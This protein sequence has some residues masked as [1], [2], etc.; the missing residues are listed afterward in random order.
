MTRSI[1]AVAIAAF[2]LAF[3]AAAPAPA[4]YKIIRLTSDPASDDVPEWSP[5]GATIA[6]QSTRSGDY[7]IYTVPAAGGAV[8]RLTS[9]PGD[10]GQPC[11][12]PDGN[13]ICFT[14]RLV[15]YEDED[16]CIMPASGGGSYINFTNDPGHYDGLPDWSPDGN[17]IAFGSQR[18]SPPPP[19]DIEYI[20]VQPYPS[21]AATKVTPGPWDDQCVDWSL[22]GT[23][24]AYS[25]W[26]TASTY[27]TDIFRIPSSGGS[28]V[29]VTN[30]H[31]VQ[32]FMPSWSPD[33]LYIAYDRYELAENNQDIYIISRNGG[34]PTRLTKDPGRDWAPAWSPDGTRIAFTSRRNNNTDIYVLYLEGNP[35]VEPSSLGKIKALFR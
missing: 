14:W 12:S 2:S 5:D 32:E 34:T 10:Q 17:Y 19:W 7:D 8:T 21:G 33:G 16:V 20:Y 22:D 28:R 6:F 3:S 13:N 35:L 1:S 24:L 26:V 11:Y 15:P 27:D 29:N 25:T 9:W 30:S 18:D 31:E 4:T 23:E